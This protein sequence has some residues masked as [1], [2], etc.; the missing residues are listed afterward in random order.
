MQ[1]LRHPF[2]GSIPAS[3]LSFLKHPT[4]HR[5]TSLDSIHMDAL[6]GWEAGHPKRR[7]RRRPCPMARVEGD[8]APTEVFNRGSVP[9]VI[10]I[11]QAVEDETK[12]K[13]WFA[14]AAATTTKDSGARGGVSWRAG[15]NGSSPEGFLP[16]VPSL[17]ILPLKTA[18]ATPRTRFTSAGRS[19]PCADQTN[20]A[21]LSPGLGCCFTD[22]SNQSSLPFFSAPVLS[23]RLV[24]PV[25][26][27][28]LSPVPFPAGNDP[29]ISRSRSP[30]TPFF[31][32][33]AGCCLRLFRQRAYFYTRWLNRAVT[34]TLIFLEKMITKQEP[35]NTLTTTASCSHRRP[36]CGNVRVASRCR[37]T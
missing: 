36:L 11:E 33:T 2:Q 18:R 17:S 32:I 14:A 31:A 37:D 5:P 10:K 30:L 12:E 6:K 15:I 8:R 23:F 27:L 34:L 7:Q 29:C 16:R 21:K 28:H 26:K 4:R 9:D 3:E 20:F 19:R 13:G 24:G 22:W 1:P 35:N 25:A